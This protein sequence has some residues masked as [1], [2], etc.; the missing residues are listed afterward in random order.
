[1]TMNIE[2]RSLRSKGFRAHHEHT[3]QLRFAGPAVPTVRSMSGE[4]EESSNPTSPLGTRRVRSAQLVISAAARSSRPCLTPSVS[5]HTR[6]LGA[7]ALAVQKYDGYSCTTVAFDCLCGES[8][9][10]AVAR[11]QWRAVW[12][13][14]L[15]IFV[16]AYQLMH[17]AVAFWGQP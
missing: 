10:P 12:T 13:A 4:T 14:S 6:T 15:F 3:T 1:M 5:A 7:N 11:R 17:T 8:T 2:I 16:F 9:C